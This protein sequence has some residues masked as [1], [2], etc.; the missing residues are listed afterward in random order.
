M[1]LKNNFFTLW[2]VVITFFCLFGCS[3][4]WYLNKAV[5]K[6]AKI[7][8]KIEYKYITKTDTIIDLVTKDTTIFERIVDSIEVETHSI[9]YIPI[10]RQE[11]K[12]LRDSSKY[13]LKAYRLE[14]SAYK[15]SLKLER[16]KEKQQR[17]KDVRH[18]KNSFGAIM[19]LLL[20]ILFIVA[21]LFTL[22][23]SLRKRL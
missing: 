18:L 10:T 19:R 13:A 21:V 5:S 22:Y 8:P 12:R 2:F 14:I 4:S 1:K 6:G 20:I 17:K 16:Y 23:Q 15:D 3:S 11:R 7:T 9:E